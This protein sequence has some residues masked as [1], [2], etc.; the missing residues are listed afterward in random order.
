[1]LASH[2]IHRCT[3]KYDAKSEMLSSICKDMTKSRYERADLVDEGE[4]E[5]ESQLSHSCNTSK[6]YSQDSEEFRYHIC[7]NVKSVYYFREQ[8]FNTHKTNNCIEGDLVGF[9]LC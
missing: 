8:E 9:Q 6:Y 4:R 1:M 5:K 3:S 7:H 2:M